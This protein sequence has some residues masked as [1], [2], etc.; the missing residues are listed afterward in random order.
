ML[1]RILDIHQSS[2][3]LQN[4]FFSD[5]RTDQGRRGDL[6]YKLPMR[7]YLSWTRLSAA[8]VE[9]SAIS[10]VSNLVFDNSISIT[11]PIHPDFEVPAW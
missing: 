3:Q 5:H 11:K 1:N 8:L 6:E 9:R 4:G 10:T 2:T 7:P